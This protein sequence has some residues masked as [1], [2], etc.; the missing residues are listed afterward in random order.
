MGGNKTYL[1]FT[2]DG[3]LLAANGAAFKVWKLGNN[4]EV[5]GFKS[6]PDRI[7]LAFSPDSR[8]L[9]VASDG[10]YLEFYDAATG[11]LMRNLQ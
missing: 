6:K 10:F 5:A 7:P 2:P 3:K 8:T 1:A 11:K 4:T 9:A